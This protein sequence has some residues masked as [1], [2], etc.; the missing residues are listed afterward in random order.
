ML[1]IKHLLLLRRNYYALVIITPILHENKLPPPC[2][3]K[4]FGNWKHCAQHGINMTY[5]CCLCWLSKLA[6][7]MLCTK[8]FGA[9]HAIILL[10]SC[11]EYF[12]ITVAYLFELEPTVQESLLGIIVGASSLLRTLSAQAALHLAED[13]LS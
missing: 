2:L 7:F 11:L 6:K 4:L 5:C 9:T 13:I 8:M 10:Q 3:F 12:Q 1:V